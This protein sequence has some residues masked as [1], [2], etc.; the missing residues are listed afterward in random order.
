M[1]STTYCA[2]HI[3]STPAG[4]VAMKHNVSGMILGL[5]Q[6]LFYACALYG[7]HKKAPFAWKLGWVWIAVSFSMSLVKLL[8][9]T[10]RLP[11]ASDP[12]IAFASVIIASTGVH[13]WLGYLWN[14]QKSY[15]SG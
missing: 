4:N 13:L 12:W 6:L 15:F 3:Y 7:I 10:L 2:Y 8:P 9:L 14:R 1:V 11:G 5:L